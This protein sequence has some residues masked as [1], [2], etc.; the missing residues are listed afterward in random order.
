MTLKINDVEVPESQKS[1]LKEVY[2]K[3]YADYLKRK[4]EILQ[5]GEELEP[6]LSALGIVEFKPHLREHIDY[7][8]SSNF[9]SIFANFDF[10]FAMAPNDPYSKSN[11]SW[12]Q[13][14]KHIISIA[15]QAMTSNEIIEVILKYYESQLTKDKLINSVPSTLSVAA[16]ENKLLRLQRENGEYEYAVFKEKK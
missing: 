1:F 7:D 10:Y 6:I 13:K 2:Q 14:C 16:K 4:D 15:N 3:R 12:L 9:K 8:A 5:E 11:W